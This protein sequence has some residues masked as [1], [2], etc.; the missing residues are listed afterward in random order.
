M[1]SMGN[2]PPESATVRA[3][4][5]EH[6]P[7]LE[8]SEPDSNRWNSFHIPLD[9]GYRL[10]VAFP[11]LYSQIPPDPEYRCEFAVLR[12][13]FVQVF[14]DDD[15]YAVWSKEDIIKGIE[16]AIEYAKTH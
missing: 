16:T 15:V 11:T 7:S 4:I 6:F 5:T 1:F 2:I 14:I 12:E 3:L 9:N 13:G 8:L 10:S